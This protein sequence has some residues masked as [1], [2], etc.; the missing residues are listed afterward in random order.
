MQTI[1][2][3][4]WNEP[5][6]SLLKTA[7]NEVF[8]VEQG[9]D[10]CV[11]ADDYDQTCTHIIYTHSEK[12]IASCR[13]RIE[14]TIAFIERVSVL[15]EYRQQS[16]SKG[17]LNEALTFIEKTNV[18][19]VAIVAQSRLISMYEKY[20]FTPVD[21]HFMIFGAS[22]IKMTKSINN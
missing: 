12:V 2:R 5:I 22:H 9:L 16:L 20:G 1:I 17:I 4:I 13:V 11:V 10:T 7:R 18:Q 6:W 19:T 21:D 14:N 8:V 3:N 15:K